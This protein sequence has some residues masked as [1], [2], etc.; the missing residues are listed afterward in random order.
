MVKRGSYQFL[1]PQTREGH[2]FM[3]HF[4]ELFPQSSGSGVPSVLLIYTFLLI[5]NF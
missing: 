4:S 5:G 1:L 2:L 3:T